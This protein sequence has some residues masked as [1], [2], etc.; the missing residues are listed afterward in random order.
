MPRYYF[1]TIASAHDIRPQVPHDYPSLEVA[2]SEARLQL[3]RMA[4][5]RLPSDPG[6][7][8]SVEIFAEDMR[9]LVELRLMFQEIEKDKEVPVE[10]KPPVE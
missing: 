10:A 2:R 6:E 4:T 1:T 8:L 5:E 9:P 7:M 3:A